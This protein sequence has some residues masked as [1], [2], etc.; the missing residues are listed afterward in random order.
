MKANN[1]SVKSSKF[2]LHGKERGRGLRKRYIAL[3]CVN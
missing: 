3:L 2:Y 1:V